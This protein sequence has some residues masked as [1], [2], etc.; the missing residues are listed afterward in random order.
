ML[1]DHRPDHAAATPAAPPLHDDGRFAGIPILVNRRHRTAHT[2]TLGRAE[3]FLLAFPWM[4]TATDRSLTITY[5]RGPAERP[6][7]FVVP[8]ERVRV[9]EGEMFDVVLADRS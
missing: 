3:L 6:Q 8:G 5:R 7:G 2:P 4:T 9:V 1:H